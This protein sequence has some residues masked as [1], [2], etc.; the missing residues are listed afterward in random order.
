[1]SGVLVPQQNLTIA[2][3]P[4][5]SATSPG[6]S[7]PIPIQGPADASTEVYSFNGE[8]GVTNQGIG[9]V[10]SDGVTPN[11]VG[12][13]TNFLSQVHIGDTLTLGTTDDPNSTSVIA[14][15]SNTSLTLS[16]SLHAE[17]GINYFI[18]TPVNRTNGETTFVKIQDQAWRRYLMNRDV[19]AIHVFGGDNAAGLNNKPLFLKESL[20]LETDQTLLLEFLNYDT[21][22]ASFAPIAEGRKWQYN[23][24][25]YKEVYN[26]I[27]D[28]RQRKQY[29]Q[30]YWLTLD[31]GWSTMAAP[32]NTQTTELLTCTGDITLVLFNCYAQAFDSNS[33]FDVSSLVTVQFQ[34]AKTMR[35]MQSQPLPLNLAGGTARNPFRLPS[36]WIVEP[37]TQIKANFVNN[38]G[39]AANV[40]LTF[41][42]VAIY[43]GSSWHGSTLTNQRLK[44]EA[45]RMYEAM[46]TP[47]IRKA[48]VQ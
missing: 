35:S 40:Y 36:P 10:T 18:L 8:Q 13:G 1:M 37:Q 47:Q 34:D 5:G 29:A 42:G 41:Q 23:A 25:K 2:K 7:T 45:S 9:V 48:D 3:I 11:I 38:S 6:R 22:P 21:A 19:P 4:A 30:P 44:E 31:K 39:A 14:V 33:S 24:M 28:L 26:F 12:T 15:N 16:G 17:S 27:S 32:V 20:L 46:S 43:T